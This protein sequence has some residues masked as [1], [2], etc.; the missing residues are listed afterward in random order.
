LHSESLSE[1]Y[2]LQEAASNK[3]DKELT[4]DYKTFL[5]TFGTYGSEEE[6]FKIKPIF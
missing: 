1:K 2:R 3:L 6:D 5:F 4:K